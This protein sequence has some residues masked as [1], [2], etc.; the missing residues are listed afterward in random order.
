MLANAAA[1]GSPAIAS[2][3]NNPGYN[4]DMSF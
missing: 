2:H 3:F 1:L 4:L